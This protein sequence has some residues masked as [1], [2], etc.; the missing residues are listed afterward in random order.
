MSN[1]VDIYDISYEGAGVGRIDGQVVF[2]PKALKNE[3]VAVEITKQNANFLVGKLERVIVASERR[4]EPNCKY[5]AECGGCDFQQC[6]Y[7][8]E[9]EIKVNIL[10]KEL[11]KVGYDGEITLVPSERRFGYRNKIKLEIKDGKLGYF[12]AKSRE[13]LEIGSCAIATQKINDCFDKIESFIEK[14]NFSGLKSVYIKQVGSSIGICFLFEKKCRFSPKKVKNLDF[15]EG[16]LVF[17]AF[18]DVLE[19]NSTK[20]FKVYGSGKLTKSFNGIQIGVDISAFNQINDEIEGK[21]YEY[22]VQQ[23]VGKRVINAYSGQGLLTYEIAKKAKFVYGIEYQISAHES[24][25]RLS[26]LSEEYKI[27]NICGRVEQ[28]LGGVLLRDKIDCI[29]LDPARE[30]CDKK[31]LDEILKSKIESVIYVSCNFSTLVRDLKVLC[32]DYAVETVKIFDMFA[33]CAGFETVAIIK[34]KV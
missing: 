17:F 24:A 20:I 1:I 26:A 6:D 23:C 4:I 9:Q 22:I 10:K 7:L 8:L 27:E 2:V 34:R 31:V 5:F 28:C 21:L 14:N 19:S 32:V 30:G 11:S 13:F 29:V 15:F 16:K 33:C 12:K 25:E 3:K 18:G